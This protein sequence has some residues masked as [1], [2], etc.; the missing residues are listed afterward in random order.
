MRSKEAARAEAMTI[1]IE[2]NDKALVSNYAKTLG[3]TAS[4][5]MRMAALE[6]VEEGL[7]L[8][9]W[10]EAKAEY[11]DN[12]VSFSAEEIAQNISDVSFDFQPR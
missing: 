6:R 7:D 5:F 9:A 10:H 12:P 3:M 4:E 8:R 1:Y 11:D 2:P